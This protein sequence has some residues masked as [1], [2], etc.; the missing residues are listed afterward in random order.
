MPFDCSSSCSLLFY[1]FFPAKTS[2]AYFN[3]VQF[4]LL[5]SESQDN[6]IEHG[7]LLIDVITMVT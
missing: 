5:L 3:V 1:Y 7:L 6:S 4:P 2:F